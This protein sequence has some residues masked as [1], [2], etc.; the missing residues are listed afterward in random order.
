V[1][2][3]G[4]AGAAIVS[5]LVAVLHEKRT[6]IINRKMKILFIIDDLANLNKSTKVFCIKISEDR[7]KMRSEKIKSSDDSTDQ[8]K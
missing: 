7:L 6:N 1:P 3:T 8:V 4:A 5:G 2:F